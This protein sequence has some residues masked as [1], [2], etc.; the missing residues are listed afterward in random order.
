M[1]YNVCWLRCLSQHPIGAPPGIGGGKDWI[2]CLGEGTVQLHV[3]HP[4]PVNKKYSPLVAIKAVNLLQY[5]M[6]LQYITIHWLQCT[7]SSESITVFLLH[8]RAV[9]LYIAVCRLLQFTACD[10][11]QACH[12]KQCI[13]TSSYMSKCLDLRSNKLTMLSQY[14]AQL[15]EHN[16]NVIS[17]S[18]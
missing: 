3:F 11:H 14:W 16:C 2:I 4:L 10:T 1:K 17:Q 6:F 5:S 18:I 8:C 15:T 13:I 7:P 9:N 12:F